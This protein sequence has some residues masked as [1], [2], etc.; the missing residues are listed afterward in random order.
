MLV[1][2]GIIGLLAFPVYAG[3]TGGGASPQYGGGTP[4]S[5]SMMGQ[6]PWWDSGQT[7][8]SL[9]DAV[10]QFEDYIAATGN[11][12]LA[13][14]E[15]ME[16][17]YNYYAI[18][19]EKSTGVGTFE[20]LIDKAGGYGRGGMGGMM[21]GGM[22]GQVGLVYPEPG[23]NMMWNTKYNMMEGMMGARS[24]FISINPSASA[25]MPV[26]AE[27]AKSYSMNYLNK[28]MPGATLEEPDRF[29]GYYTIHILKDGKIVGMLSV[30]GYTGDVWYHSWHGYFIQER[31]LA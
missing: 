21:G 14:M 19:Y 31:D 20:L 29:Y 15:V 3:L 12:D 25:D 16:F 8:I 1:V 28:Q 11:K 27:Q 5:P 4:W 17:Q 6:G 23:P 22:M 13:L 9:D 26:S 18:V 10:R 2:L 24:G 30:N 7:Q